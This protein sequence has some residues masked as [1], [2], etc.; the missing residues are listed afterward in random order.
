MFT[1]ERASAISGLTAHTLRF[2][3]KSGILPHV[4]RNSAG[5]RC[6]SPDDI[7]WIRFV[8]LLKATGMPL[9]EI[10]AFV[11]A[12][13]LGQTGFAKK[14]EILTKHRARIESSLTDLASF[15]EKIESKIEFY[16]KGN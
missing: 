8:S 16:T 13:K 5:H 11:G 3:E 7:G 2:Y 10:R 1:I 15:L 12:E 14:I 6:Y 4:G 9:A